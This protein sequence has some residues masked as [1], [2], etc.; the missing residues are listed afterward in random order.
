[1]IGVTRLHARTAPS[2]LAGRLTSACPGTSCA[3]GTLTAETRGMNLR[4]FAVRLGHVHRLL[5]HVHHLSFGVGT[6]SASLSPGG[7]TTHKTALMAAT[8]TTVVSEMISE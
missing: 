6:G 5:L 7:V 1:M 4:S 8:R 3:M 2:S